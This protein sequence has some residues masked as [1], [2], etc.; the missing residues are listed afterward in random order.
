MML[1]TDRMV[2]LRRSVIATLLIVL[3]GVPPGIAAPGDTGAAGN[4]DWSSAATWTNGAPGARANAYVGTSY[5]TGAAATA[6]LTLSQNSS[7]GIVYLG[8]GSGNTGT[9]NLGGFTLTTYG[10]YLGDNGGAGTIQRTGGGTLAVSIGVYQNSGGNFSFAPGDVANQLYVSD[11]STAA[12]SAAG[13]VTNYVELDPGGALALGAN[14]SLADT[15]L[16]GP[17]IPGGPL[18]PPVPAAGVL[19]MSGTLNANGHAI[20]A[21]TIAIGSDGGPVAFLN[22]GLVTAGAWNQGGGS[23]IRLNQPGDTLG[24][25]SL[26]GNSILTIGDTAGQTSGTTL[27]NVLVS[28]LSVAAGSDLALEVNGLAGGWVFRWADPSGG[29][30]IADLQNFINAGEITFSYL[31]GGS[32]TITSDGGYTYVN[33]MPVPEP[34]ALLLMASAGMAAVLVRRHRVPAAQTDTGQRDG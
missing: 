21:S 32:Y 33:V 29:D 16:L 28:D 19:R 26:T 25:V 15:T 6:S 27:G 20:A 14:L 2:A 5:P 12:T 18:P 8:F 4:G 13:N 1:Y 23:Q 17:G 30:H 3:L 22:D 31:N 10:L 7:A 9:L 34:S 24:S 11:G